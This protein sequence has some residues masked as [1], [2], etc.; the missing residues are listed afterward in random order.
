M[1]SISEDCRQEALLKTGA[2]Q[3][4]I[5]NSANFSSIATDAKGVIQIFN[6]GAE[7]MLGYAA[8]EVINKITPADIS[9]PQEVVARAKSLS[10]ELSTPIT[11]GF[12]ALVFKASRGIEDIY[13]LTYIRKDRSRFPAVVS[14]T[15]LRDDENTVIGY[16]LIGTDNT[17]RKKAEEAL[18]KAGALQNAIFNSANF[19]SIATD[20]KGVIQIFNVG[21]ERMLGYAAVEVMN[22]ITPADISDP[23]EVVARAKALSIELSTPITPGFEALVFK[24][25][26]GIEDIYELT[27]IRKD[28][29]RFPA[30]VSVTALRDDEN[31]IIGYLL[32][33]TDN[34]ARKQVEAEQKKLDQRVR[35]QQ[36]YTRSLIES[37]IDALII[38]NPSGIITDANKQMEAITSCTRDEL[39]GSPFRNHFNDP[40]RAEASISLVLREKKVIDYELTV[41]AMDGKKTPV[42]LHATTIYDRDRKLQGVLA[43]VRDMSERKRL[44]QVLQDKNAELESARSIAERANLAKSE[45]LASMSHEIRTPMN[46]VIGLTHLCLHTEL[47]RQQR[48]YL[49]KVSVSANVLLQLI[50]DILDFSKIEAGKLTMENVAFILDDVLGGVVAILSVKSHEKGLEFLLDTKK[51]VPH[52]LRGDSHRLGQILTNLAGNAIKFTE[53]GEV[54]IITEVLEETRDSVFLQFTVRD[55]GIGMTPEQMSRLFQ[56]FSQG[57]ASITRKYGGTGLGLAIS[58]R[59]V[60]MMDGQICV[61]NESEH[62]SRFIFTA[63][64][65]KADGPEIQPLVPAEGI[66]GLRIL[67]VDDNAS[68]RKIISEQLI[69]LAYQPVSVGSGESAIQVLSHA[70][71]EGSPFDLVFMDWKMPGMNG[72]E[73]ARR[74]KK[75]LP[76]NEIPAVIMVTAYGQEYIATTEEEKKLLNGFLMKPVTINAVLDVIMIAFGYEPIR[77]TMYYSNTHRANLAGLKLLLVEDNLINQQVAQELL[78]QAGTVVVVANN[79]LE[80]IRLLDKE[81][82]DGILMD[83][84]M[85]VMDGLTATQR[86]RKK[87]SAEELPII[88]M[89]A[90]AMAGDRE[91][92]LQAGMNDHIA[93]PV[94]P[95]EMYATLAKWFPSQSDLIS[96]DMVAQ[97][98]GRGKD[99]VL[100]LPPIPGIDL[101]RG[102]RN[103]GGNT[104]LYRNVLLMFAHNQGGACQEM[105]RCWASGNILMLERA[106]HTLK[107][108]SATIGAL[109]LSGLAG[110]IE[111]QS[112]NPEGMKELRKLFGTTACE[113][114]RI[115]STIESTLIQPEIL[116]L[117]ENQSGIEIGLEDLSLLLNQAIVLLLAYDTSVENV[118]EEIGAFILSGR[119]REKIETIKVALGKYDY[120]TCIML[121]RAWAKEEAIDLES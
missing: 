66:S 93:K 19:S 106:A 44:D 77:Q 86:I 95:D 60:E 43:A 90:N 68:A 103:V 116:A 7:R 20:A 1:E 85:P 81:P 117:N 4:A 50:N 51:D 75:E 78:E 8:A 16:L 99:I 96:R 115:V 6:V 69:S 110:K 62:G 100:P 87:M 39:I 80:A 84:Q 29:S 14:V 111:K 102:L 46:G 64:F 71:T 109:E 25:S 9:D 114:A 76:L 47:T 73:V 22:K 42:S 49:S 101:A 92:C 23:Y 82:F 11:P 59:L 34:T 21:A 30:V 107:G 24:A 33:G 83:L 113:L 31:T 72:L 54:T 98:V 32:I 61:E 40:E 41:W 12:E 63:R 56:E 119:R 35:D 5:F 118:L 2:L 38:T 15:A 74:I 70:D 112:R 108:V 28:G 10:I 13:E 37:S 55:T 52:A 91:R 45:F 104:V 67:V 57:D 89:T 120:E 105:E 3:N 94:D 79:G 65:N 58:K 121:F 27:Y 36:F 48:D 17:A 88:A 53:T 18:L 97:S 26:R